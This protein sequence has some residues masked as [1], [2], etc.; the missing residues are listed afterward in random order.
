MGSNS[1][2]YIHECTYNGQIFIN[3]EKSHPARCLKCAFRGPETTLTAT[4]GPV[5]DED[6]IRAKKTR[7]AA[8]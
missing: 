3:L 8:R 6:F 1:P 5:T 2:I 7:P 4:I